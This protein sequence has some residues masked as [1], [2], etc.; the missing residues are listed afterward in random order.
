MKVLITADRIQ[1]Q[2][3]GPVAIEFDDVDMFVLSSIER[4][5]GSL[6]ADPGNTCSKL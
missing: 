4:V 3:L 1:Q 2:I 6:H 5:T